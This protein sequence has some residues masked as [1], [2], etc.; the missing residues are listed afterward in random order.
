MGTIYHTVNVNIEDYEAEVEIDSS[1]VLE[2]VDADELVDALIGQE[3][4]KDLA[5]RCYNCDA[6]LD[7]IR[8]HNEAQSMAI[9]IMS[10]NPE[11]FGAAMAE[12]K[13]ADDRL[14]ILRRVW[15]AALVDMTLAPPV[16]LPPEEE[17]LG[18]KVRQLLEAAPLRDVLNCMML[19]LGSARVAMVTVALA[20]E[21]K[22]E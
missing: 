11:E 5:E 16:N 2:S 10:D 17:P 22:P 7:A 14:N 18:E 13:T 15:T 4:Y 9:H 6:M 8:N 3:S 1:E 20:V 19:Q 21:T 12:I